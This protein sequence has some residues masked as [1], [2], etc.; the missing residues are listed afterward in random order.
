MQRGFQV[1]NEVCASCHSLNLVAFRSL[2]E[3]DFTEEQVKAFAAEY[4]VFTE[5]DAYGEVEEVT[6]EPT[7][8]IRGKG[9]FE[10]APDLSLMNKARVGGADYTHALLTGYKEPP[11]GVETPAG[12]YYNEYFPGN[13]ISMPQP[14]WGEDVSYADGTEP[15]LEQEAKDVT[16]FMMWAAEPHLED[17]K[18]MGVKV[19]LFLIVFTGM[20]YAVKRK[21]WADLH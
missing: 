13:W 6:A 12:L 5:P 17:R 18:R 16:A 20:L 1:Y 19:L 14:L 2:E 8:R 21:V 9:V 7:D 3:L 11:E 10:N 4:T 15:T